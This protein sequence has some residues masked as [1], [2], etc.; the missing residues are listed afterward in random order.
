MNNT[1]VVHPLVDQV[2]SV[3]PEN[4][5]LPILRELVRDIQTKSSDE[6]QR[7]SQCWSDSNWK[8]WRQHSSHN[9]W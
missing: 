2:Q 7:D 3:R 1:E 9:P 4:I 6:M 5:E 8:Q